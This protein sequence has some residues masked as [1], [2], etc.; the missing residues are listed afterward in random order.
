[1]IFVFFFCGGGGGGGVRRNFQKVLEY[2]E[3]H[4]KGN[5]CCDSTVL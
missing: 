1:M 4:L 5:L 3:E 2:L